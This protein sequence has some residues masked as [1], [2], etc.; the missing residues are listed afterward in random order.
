MKDQFVEN[1]IQYI[2]TGDY[3]IPDIKL[4]EEPR[5]IGRFG[6]M[7]RDYLRDHR[8]VLYNQLILADKL[9]THLADTQEAAQTR[10]DLLI[11]QMVT[12]E[13]VNE[14][15]KEANQMEWV[16]RMNSIQSRAEEVVLSEIV[17][18]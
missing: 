12:A 10:L 1:G 8:P 17:Y 7:R 4:N 18:E 15:M 16:Q 14:G 3:Y 6:R 11:R 2:R 9:W 13:G 5:P